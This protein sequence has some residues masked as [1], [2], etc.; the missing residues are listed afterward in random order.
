MIHLDPAW[1]PIVAESGVRLSRLSTRR[2]ASHIYRFW[3]SWL[4]PTAL[5]FGQAGMTGHVQRC[6]RGHSGESHNKPIFDQSC[7][8]P[9]G[10]TFAGK[11]SLGTDQAWAKPWIA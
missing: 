5:D 8:V 10:P 11:G 9:D 4:V 3:A 2:V 6:I 1:D 7:T